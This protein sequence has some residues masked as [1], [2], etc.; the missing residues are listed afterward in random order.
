MLDYLAP[1]FWQDGTHAK[2]S[3][4]KTGDGIPLKQNTRKIMDQKAGKSRHY[5]HNRVK[6]LDLLDVLLGRNLCG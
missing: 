1:A 4:N 3:K 5:F 2:S 6:A